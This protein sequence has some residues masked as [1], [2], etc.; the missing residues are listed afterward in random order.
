MVSI[1]VMTEELWDVNHSSIWILISF[2]LTAIDLRPV[3]MINS[4]AAELCLFACCRGVMK[5]ALFQDCRTSWV[6]SLVVGSWID[7]IWHCWQR[8]VL[9]I[10]YFTQEN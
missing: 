7:C 5:P 4:A 9:A 2:P 6:W 3:Q 1:I 8:I 10:T